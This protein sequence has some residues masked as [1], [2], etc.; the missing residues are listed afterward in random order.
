[1]DFRQDRFNNGSFFEALNDESSEDKDPNPSKD[2]HIDDPSERQMKQLVKCNMDRCNLLRFQ[3][4]LNTAGSTKTVRGMKQ[5]ALL[6]GKIGRKHSLK[7][8]DENQ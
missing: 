3:L 8:L 6:G 7:R 2:N 1:M 4:F 5:T